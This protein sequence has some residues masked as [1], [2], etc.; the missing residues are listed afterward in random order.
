MCS[1]AVV[2]RPRTE[3]M[4]NRSSIPGRGKIFLFSAT[5]Q[6]VRPTH[7]TVLWVPR[8]FSLGVKR[9]VHE[10]DHSF[11]SNTRIKAE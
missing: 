7:L 10:S 8:T 11:A 4:R 1:V 3:Q 6:D 9:P 5:G 2:T